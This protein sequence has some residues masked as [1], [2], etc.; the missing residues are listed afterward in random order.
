MGGR[1]ETA[2]GRRKSLTKPAEGGAGVLGNEEARSLTG[3]EDMQNDP[4]KL[5]PSRQ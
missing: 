4:V 2:P 3:M 5:K 1:G